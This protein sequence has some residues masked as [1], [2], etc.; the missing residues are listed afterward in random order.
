MLE[1]TEEG[2]TMKIPYLLAGVLSGVAAGASSG[3]TA[4]ANS[5][6]LP[7]GENKLLGYESIAGKIHVSQSALDQ[8]VAQRTQLARKHW[9]ESKSGSGSFGESWA[10]KKKKTSNVDVKSTFERNQPA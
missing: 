5:L 9:H 7:A 10:R 3:G 6:G 2:R 8:I 4:K 1:L